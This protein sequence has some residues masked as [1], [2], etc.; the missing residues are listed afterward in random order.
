MIVVSDTS[1]VSNLLQVDLL[2]ILN[3]VYGKVIVPQAVYE[4]LC[5]IEDQKKAIDSLKWIEIESASNFELIKRLE[6]D[7]D[8]GESEAIALAIEFKADFLIIDELIGR[9]I[10]ESF[11]SKNCWFARYFAESQR[12]WIDSGYFSNF[13]KPLYKGRL[14]H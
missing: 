1:A 6:S 11:R 5:E 7:L 8:A 3:L 9:R 13:G 14:S 10:A 2:H 4:E 12:K